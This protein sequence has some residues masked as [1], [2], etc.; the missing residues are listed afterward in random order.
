MKNTLLS[1][2]IL[3]TIFFLNSCN[4]SS[5]SE[6]NEIENKKQNELK[7]NGDKVIA[8][9]KKA[10]S[11][12]AN[13]LRLVKKPE[14]PINNRALIKL[15]N[16]SLTSLGPN[17]VNDFDPAKKPEYSIEA[18]QY[19]SIGPENY[20][21]AVMGITNPND[22]H[23]CT[24]SLNIGLFQYKNQKWNKVTLLKDLELLSGYGNYGSFDK[25]ELFGEK[26]VCTRL[27]GGFTQG[28]NTD[29]DVSIV[30]VIDNTLSIIYKGPI[31][32]TSDDGSKN[33]NTIISFVNTG[34][35]YYELK[36]VKLENDYVVKTTIKVFN[37]KKKKYE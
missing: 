22:C 32:F 7:S 19:Y 18:K 14:N 20:L 4:N 12:E 23:L 26:N 34:K 37:E 35:K 11:S 1:T 21:L 15:F 6:N 10:D 16:I 24:G 2:S 29:T 8:E 30:G 17:F 33:E 3:V 27:I 36:E 9:L 25:L 31:G 13:T 5:T 28:G